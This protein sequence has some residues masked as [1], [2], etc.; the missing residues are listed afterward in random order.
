[1]KKTL[2]SILLLFFATTVFAQTSVIGLPGGSSGVPSVNGIS[3]A[4]TI[5]G[6][7]VSTDSSTITVAGT[8]VTPPTFM[9]YVSGGTTFAVNGKTQQVAFSGTDAAVVINSILGTLTNTGGTLYF[10]SG[11]YNLNS[12]TLETVSPYSNI[13]YAVGIP[14]TN[15]TA[16]PSF[17]FEGEAA[18]IGSQSNPATT[19]VIFN[20]TTA[21]ETVAG[22]NFLD[23]FWMRPNTTCDADYP[24]YPG[25]CLY[26][27]DHVSFRNLIVNFPNNAHGKEHGIDMLEASYLHVEHVQIGFAAMATARGASG[28]VAI[29]TPATPSD[30]DLIEETQIGPGYDIAYEVNTEHSILI[31]TETFEDTTCYYYAA[32]QSRNLG[33]PSHSSQFIHPQIYDCVNGILTG[34]LN[35]GAQLDIFGLDQQYA[36]SGTWTKAYTF[37]PGANLGGFLSWQNTS[38]A[39][40]IGALTTPFEAGGGS[41]YVVESNGLITASAIIGNALATDIPTISFTTGTGIITAHSTNLLGAVQVTSSGPVAFQLN[42]VKNGSAFSYPNSSNCVF[43]VAANNA[44]TIKVTAGLASSLQAAGSTSSPGEYVQY[45]CLG[46]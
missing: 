15:A 33:N 9:F 37:L 14:S 29:R 18:G 11:T 26:W 20:V 38:D 21:A 31:N 25:S 6:P 46:N 5:S 44:D 28:T 32:E 10:K 39:G 27:N 7:G 41:N 16:Y 3:S 30:G 22:A 4:V 42:W 19:G 1:M 45:I 2:L 12:C 23:A 8:G 36:T 24:P 34:A 35:A 43:T 13:C 17:A 40:A